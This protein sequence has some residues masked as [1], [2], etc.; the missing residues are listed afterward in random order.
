M[1]NNKTDC[2][3]VHSCA[4]ACVYTLINIRIDLI[5]NIFKIII[6][7]SS[8]DST[9]RPEVL[10][11]MIK[12]LQSKLTQTSEKVAALQEFQL[13]VREGDATYVKQNFKYNFYI[14]LYYLFLYYYYYFSFTL[15]VFIFFF[16][17]LTY[18]LV[19][20]IYSFILFS[21]YFRKLLKTLLDRVNSD[22]QQLQIEVLQTL[23]DMLKCPELLESFSVFPELLVLKVITAH[24]FD[25]QKADGSSS[26]E[27][28]RAPVR[29][30]EV[31]V[32]S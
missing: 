27:S 20:T 23:I 14:L 24:K 12:T 6:S 19:L 29:M 22:S 1:V 5:R 13:Y 18:P 9:K 15:F 32:R 25:D 4:R 10:D 30:S 17:S 28:V 26:G 2:V 11:N 31:F 21:F 3:C 16:V 7:G 8:P